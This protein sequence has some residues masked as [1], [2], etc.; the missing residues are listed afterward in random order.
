VAW[1][2]EKVSDGFVIWNFVVLVRGE[3]ALQLEDVDRHGVHTFSILPLVSS[4]FCA[5]V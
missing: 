3:D 5:F 1:L 4:F 2:V